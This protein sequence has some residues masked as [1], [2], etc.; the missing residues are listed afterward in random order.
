[1]NEV[2]SDWKFWVFVIAA[3]NFIGIIIVGLFNKLSHDKL[4]SNDLSH[5]SS[6]IKI[7]INKQDI[8]EN[9]FVVLSDSV[10]YLKGSYDIL[11]PLTLQKKKRKSKIKKSKVKK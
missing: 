5:I 6:D 4:V 1:M 10:S 8:L 7:I 9:K 3:L 2:F 11:R